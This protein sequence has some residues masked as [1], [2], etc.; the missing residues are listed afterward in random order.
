MEL[1]K[2]LLT[3]AITGSL[4]ALTGCT[5][6]G[7][8]GAPGAP[9]TSQTL[10]EL[11]VLGT[12]ASGSF[13]QSAAEI[14]AHDPANQRLFVINS[15][16]RSVDVLDINDPTIPSLLN[17][18]D[19]TL[20]G[21]AAN[22]VAVFGNLLAVAI[23]AN[24][25][26]D[27][28]KVVFY[29]TTDLGKI[30]EVNVGALPD[31]VTFTR[32]GQALL[33][34]NEGEPNADYSIDPE[35]SVSIID[36]SNGVASATVT[37]ADFT[38][39]NSQQTALVAKGLRVFGP[40]ATLAQDMEPEYIAVS[41]DNTK[42]W[43][44]LQ[45]NNAVAELDIAAG[46]ITAILPLGF[47][48]YN[49]IG[50][51]LDASNRDGG[52]NIRNWPVKGMY[53]PDSIASYGY[54]GK[55]YYLTANEGDARDYDTWTEEFRVGDL[56]LNP[57]AFPDRDTLQ[58]EEN[59]GRLRVTSTLGVS[60][61]CDPSD[62]AINAALACEYDELFSYGARS[63]SIWSEDGRRVFDSGSE[64]ER[65][66]ASLIPE[67]F[68]ASND[69]NESDARSDDKGPEPEAITVGEINGQTFAFI[70]LERVGGIM[71]YNV[72]NPQNPEFVQY[73]NNRDFSVSQ[74]DLENG[75]AGDLGPEGFA[76]IP[77]GQSPNS[78]PMLAVGNEVS[79]TTTFYGI[80]VIEL[81]AK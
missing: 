65:I 34:A 51:E 12:Y 69:D 67:G 8:D 58:L 45:E 52:I 9:G 33:V 57:T 72:T 70:G 30:G 74:V 42:A 21:G 17:T 1:R 10:I 71:V 23:E 18:I 32:D 15:L 4:V 7:N 5:D 11:N 81:T 2:S 80:D 25:K 62:I 14:V 49:L 78:K 20:E 40:G 79:G 3:L 6:D 59:L 54:N 76:F 29:N 64:F 75:L 24:V 13:D 63:F 73:I 31:M 28:G 37:T 48:D 26:Q 27:A 50:N 39:F 35:G 16:D 38:D 44:A 68:N 46:E 47:K 60:N 36:L 53:Q 61:G 56:V 41:I 19:A 77:A 43:V 55:T 66:T 22:S